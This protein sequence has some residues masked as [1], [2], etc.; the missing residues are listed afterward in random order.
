M[1]PQERH[2]LNIDWRQKFD[3]ANHLFVVANNDWAVICAFEQ[4]SNIA[5]KQ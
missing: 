4:I 5:T 3:K 1:I 2:H